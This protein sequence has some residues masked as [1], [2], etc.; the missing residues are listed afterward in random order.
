MLFKVTKYSKKFHHFI[1]LLPKL[2]VSGFSSFKNMH[3]YVKIKKII[4]FPILCPWNLGEGQVYLK[5]AIPPPVF[6]L[7]LNTFVSYYKS[8]LLTKYGCYKYII[9]CV[10]VLLRKTIRLG[11]VVNK[12]LF[13]HILLSRIMILFYGL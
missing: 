5:L 3:L 2:S 13:K 9:L 8:S 12:F 10:C 1:C 11:I 4:F 6:H 7:I